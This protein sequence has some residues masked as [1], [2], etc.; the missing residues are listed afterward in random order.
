MMGS[1]HSSEA[2]APQKILVFQQRGSAESKIAGISR[3][4]NGAFALEIFSIDG[5]L[6]TLI[7]DASDYL[8]ERITADL[9]LD[10]LK[11]P[12]LSQ[13]LAAMCSRL[14]I[15]VVASGKKLHCKGVLTPPT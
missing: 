11:H 5:P 10:Y 7:D 8:P 9:V 3:F 6:P 4:G 15:P 13:D 14:A 12:D 2:T 1:D